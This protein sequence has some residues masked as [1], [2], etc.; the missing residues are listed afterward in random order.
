[1][2]RSK[3]RERYTDVL[4]TPPLNVGDRLLTMGVFKDPN[5]ANESQ[6]RLYLTLSSALPAMHES[7]SAESLLLA[8]L[9]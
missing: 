1:M 8:S 7:D 5:A 3:S 9:R 6:R 4:E 2:S